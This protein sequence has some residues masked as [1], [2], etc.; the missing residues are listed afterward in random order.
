MM[1]CGDDS[2]RS[3]TVPNRGICSRPLRLKNNGP[4]DGL[5]AMS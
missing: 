1:K 4:W 3:W 2:E 5:A